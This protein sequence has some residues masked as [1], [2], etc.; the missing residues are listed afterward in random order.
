MAVPEVLGWAEVVGLVIAGIVLV[1]MLGTLI[2]AGLP[3]LNALVGVG[4]GALAALAF[5]SVVEMNSV[6]PVLGVMLVLAVGIDY[7]LFIVHRHRTQLKSGMALRHS[8]AMA[9]GT[10]GNAVVFA[11]STVVIALLALN[12][13][14]IP[15]LGLMGTV[16]GFVVVIAVLVAIT[17][18]PA[19]LSLL[20]VRA[21]SKRERRAVAPQD[22]QVA[23]RRPLKPMS[24]ARA[25][26]TAIGTIA[27]LAIVAIPVFSMRLG[28][29][30]GSSEAPDTTEYQ[31]YAAQ[32]EHFGA[33]RNAPIV[34]VADIPA[35]LS[36]QDLLTTTAQQAEEIA[37]LDQVQHVV[38][39]GENEAGD[40]LMFQIIP[41]HDAN[42]EQTVNLVYELRGL[43]PA[44]EV[45]QLALAG[46]A[47]GVIDV[48]D[49]L[50]EVLPLYLGVVVGLSLL[51]MILVFRSL[52]VPLIASGGFVLSV[53]AAMGAVV[54]IYQWGWLGDI[55]MVHNPSPVLSFLPTIMIGVLF[56]LAMDYQL[57][58][59]SGMREA[60]AHGT[61]AR[62]AVQQG[63]MQGRSV[64]AA[65]AIIMVSVFG[66]FIY[67]DDPYIRPIGFGLAIGV[68]FDAFL[69]RML[70]VPALMHLLG[71][72]A[73][74]LPKWL[75]RIL[76]NVDVEGAK[77]AEFN[78]GDQR[79]TH[80][81]QATTG[82]PVPTTGPTV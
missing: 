55:F 57:F 73:W 20:G 27:V 28:I 74:Y 48:S 32:S 7:A 53:G 39:V 31:A 25:V 72:S 18:T 59:S 2:T 78:D 69:V 21:L 17:L 30:D 51:I 77:L 13:T 34:A 58:I 81:E 19:M 67:A 47:T 52:V 62:L 15:F 56:G 75:D 11:G 23:E 36:E 9:N 42:H 65:A 46:H 49:A 5:S 50:A 26:L 24:T 80:A 12:L 54:A 71:K 76:P 14:G 6:T 40:M 66:G 63:F 33:G 64:V 22:K 37:E 4:V 1:I 70:M 41:V 16:G 45:T 3:L 61:E 60:F 35:D 38:P 43:E 68:L 79:G 44:G 82:A 10:S 8:I 29:P